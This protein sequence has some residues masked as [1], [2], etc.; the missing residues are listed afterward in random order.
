MIENVEYDE[1]SFDF[2]SFGAF[3]ENLYHPNEAI[4]K[5]LKWAKPGGLIHIEVTSS[6]WLINNLLN[7]VY[8]VKGFDYV[9]NISPMH[10]LYHLYKFSLESFKLNTKENN[11]EIA[12]HEYFVF[13]KYFPKAFD[14]ILKKYW[15]AAKYL[16]KEKLKIRT[17]IPSS[18]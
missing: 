5:A 18:K 16:V 7:L 14:F 4:R 8:R 12:S 11:F 1:N 2:I 9:A 10:T 3:L 15:N 17:F 13:E 6:E